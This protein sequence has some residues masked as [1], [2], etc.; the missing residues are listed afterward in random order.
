M[1]EESVIQYLK[2]MEERIIARIDEAR[3]DVIE[4]M[5]TNLMEVGVYKKEILEKIKNSQKATKGSN[6]K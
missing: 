6:S 4:E 5:E 3:A 2:E 1:S